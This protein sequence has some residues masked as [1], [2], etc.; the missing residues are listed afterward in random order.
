MPSPFLLGCVCRL[1]KIRPAP[2][3]EASGLGVSGRFGPEALWGLP[4]VVADSKWANSVMYMA[5]S[6][7]RNE[8]YVCIDAGTK[9][10]LKSRNKKPHPSAVGKNWMPAF[11]YWQKKVGKLVSRLKLGGRWDYAGLEI[12]IL[13]AGGE[14]EVIV[15]KI[16]WMMGRKGEQNCHNDSIFSLPRSVG[17]FVP[18]VCWWQVRSTRMNPLLLHS[19]ICEHDSKV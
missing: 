2:R 6:G 1:P 9:T 8:Q 16:G 7:K 5:T 19:N 12:F 18:Q 15:S 14:G 3:F 11:S 10:K 4:P 13:Q 17:S